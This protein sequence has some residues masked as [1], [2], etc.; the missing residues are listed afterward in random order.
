ML[1]KLHNYGHGGNDPQLSDVFAPGPN[2]MPLFTTGEPS[3]LYLRSVTGTQFVKC[4][5]E[6]IH[7][8]PIYG[9]SR[10]KMVQQRLVDVKI[11]VSKTP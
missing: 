8:R 2:F 1:L 9:T 4:D 7:P 10:T 11:S 5:T 6:H 3:L